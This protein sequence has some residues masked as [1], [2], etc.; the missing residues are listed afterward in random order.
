ME[1]T[2]GTQSDD[3]RYA[4]LAKDPSTCLS[5]NYSWGEIFLLMIFFSLC[6]EMN[7]YREREVEWR[8][9]FQT[10]KE[11]E[12]WRR[13]TITNHHIQN[14]NT[15]WLTFWKSRSF[16]DKK[17]T[18]KKILSSVCFHWN[19]TQ[20]DHSLWLQFL[21]IPIPQHQMWSAFLLK[22][23]EFYIQKL[24][25]LVIYIYIYLLLSSFF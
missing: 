5:V 4:G 3:P 18:Q 12:T 2:R 19:S 15:C 16:C 1:P 20:S 25:S 8:G 17:P 13:H 6:I 21:D 11:E 10:R 23:C 24:L 14:Q 7:R 22:H 9:T